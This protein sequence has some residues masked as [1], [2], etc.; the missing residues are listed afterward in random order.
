MGAGTTATPLE[1]ALNQSQSTLT[2]G[3]VRSR[4]DASLNFVLVFIHLS[5]NED[6]IVLLIHVYKSING[7]KSV[8]VLFK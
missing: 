4:S 3:K 6:T 7:L 8:S 5:E 2:R 1:T